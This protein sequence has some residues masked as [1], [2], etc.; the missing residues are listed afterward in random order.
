MSHDAIVPIARAAKMLAE[1]KTIEQILHVEN[2]A[3]RAKDFAKAAGFA[4]KAVKAASAIMLDARRK[5]GE[6][7]K[8]M[9]ERGELAARGDA[10]KSQPA[11][12]NLE[13]LGLTRRQS[14]RYQL[15]AS[16]PEKDYRKWVKESVENE[17]AELTASR[18][19]KMAKQR[20]AQSTTQNNSPAY[21]GDVVCSLQDL[22]ERG[23]RFGCIYADPPWQYN[24][25]GTRAA[26]N[27]HY[28]TMSLKQ[29]CAE[30]VSEIA[31]EDAFLF[32]WTTTSFLRESF[33]VIDAW[34][35]TYKSNWVWVKNQFGIGNYGRVAHE[36]LMVA[37]RGKPERLGG[38]KSQRSWIQSDRASH[39]EKPQEFR[40]AIMAMASG[41]YLEMYGRLPFDGWTVYGNQVEVAA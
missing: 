13:D 16:L 10:K 3:Q 2:L 28:G 12:F 35:F 41:P 33:D 32:L 34:G 5:A 36:H 4:D 17:S 22:L 31:A 26:T 18:L 14:S 24:N 6:T 8:R 29:I 1:A 38:E 25:Q 15:E 40:T 30:P 23:E 27:N 39:S 9:Q 7:L 20:K 19:R 11:T 21:D 37:V